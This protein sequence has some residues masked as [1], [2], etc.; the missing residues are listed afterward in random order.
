[1]ESTF[2]S[3]VDLA[4]EQYWFLPM[5]RLLEHR[6]LTRDFASSISCPVLVAHGSADT[7][8]GVRH[9]KELARR[10]H[11]KEYLEAPD[12]D[13]NEI[14]LTGPYASR[15]LAFLDRAIPAEP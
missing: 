8:I 3:I 9:G 15:Y 13:H 2:T 4:K 11:A 14:L 5:G 12:V 6:F 7:L 10:F 1:M